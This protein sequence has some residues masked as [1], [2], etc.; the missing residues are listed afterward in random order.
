MHKSQASFV[1][2]YHIYRASFVHDYTHD[3]WDNF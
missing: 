2:I 1:M 3:A